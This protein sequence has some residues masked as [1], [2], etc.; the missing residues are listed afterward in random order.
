[1]ASQIISLTQKAAHNNVPVFIQG[2]HGTGKELIG[3]S[4]L[5]DTTKWMIDIN[6]AFD[7]AVNSIGKDNI[8]MYN[9][10]KVVLRCSSSKWEFALYSSSTASHEDWLVSMSPITGEVIIATNKTQ[11]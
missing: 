2:E 7:I 3:N 9:S 11:N 4:D 5:L 8:N 10:P 6:E 1:V